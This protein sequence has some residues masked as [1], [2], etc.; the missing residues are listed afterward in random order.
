MTGTSTA[1]QSSDGGLRGQAAVF[2]KDNG[3]HE[4]TA[5]ST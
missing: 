2:F 1:A 5:L 3:K 4:Q